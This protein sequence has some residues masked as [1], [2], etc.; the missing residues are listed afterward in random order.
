M[1]IPRK[2]NSIAFRQ[3]VAQQLLFCFFTIHPEKCL[4][5]VEHPDRYAYENR[6][7]VLIVGKGS[8]CLFDDRGFDGLVVSNKIRDLQEYPSGVFRAGGGIPVDA[9]GRHTARRGWG[10]LEFASGIPGTVGGAVFMNAGANGQATADTLLSVEYLTKR[11]EKRILHRDSGELDCGYRWSPF[12]D[13]P[14]LAAITAATFELHRNA[15]AGAR[16]RQLMERRL[17]TQP[18]R[19]RS[20]GCV[21]RNPS[22]QG[23]PS[24]GAL[25]DR[26]GLKG[27]SCG[28]ASV[29]EMHANFLVNRGGNHTSASEVLALIEAVK[30]KILEESGYELQEEIRQIPFQLPESGDDR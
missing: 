8:N 26:A 14:D 10:G 21:F 23:A 18:V 27:L 25:I 17:E 3:Y 7:Q 16:V 2:D 19:E 30:E 13:M 15:D 6:I 28:G 9:L 1:E 20:A 12:Q 11:G 5:A 22:E 29:S 24:A 4:C